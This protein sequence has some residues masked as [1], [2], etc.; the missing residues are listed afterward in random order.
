MCITY[1]SFTGV[2][3]SILF[4]TSIFCGGD[5]L[6]QEI[7]Q[8]QLARQYFDQ[9]DVEKAKD[10]YEKLSR[11]NSNIPLIH[12]SYIELLLVE[13]DFDQALK[14]IEKVNKWFPKNYH[15][16][17][18]EALIYR[19]SKQEKKAEEIFNGLLSDVKSSPTMLRSTAQYLFQKGEAEKAVEFYL[20]GRKSS[21]NKSDFAIELANVYRRMNN[22]EAMIEEYLNFI[23][24][25]PSNL[26]YVQ[27]VMQ[28]LLTE[29]EDLEALQ[30][31]LYDKI[32]KNPDDLVYNELLIWVNMQ[33]KDFYGAFIQA[34]AIDKRAKEGGK[35]LLDIGIMALHNK[36]YKNGETIFQYII[37]NYNEGFTY[38]IARRYLISAREEIVKNTYPVDIDQIKHLIEDYNKLIQDLGISNVSLEAMRSKALLHAFYLNERDTAINL[39]QKII[40]TQRADP[41]LVAKAKL[42]LGDI[43]LLMNQPW[44]STLLYGQVEKASKDTP[45]GYLAKL[46]NAKLSYYKGD[47]ELAQS[48]LDVL[49]LATSREIS[50]DAISLSLLIQNN[51][52]FD[53]TEEAM[54]DYARIDLILFQNKKQ[55]ALNHLDSMIIKFPGHALTD[56]IWWR[57]AN[58]L[59]ELGQFEAS[60]D[61][62]DQIVKQY[63]YDILSDDAYFL[64]G[65]ILEDYLN[66]PNE[67]MEIYQS[68]LKN[69]PGSLYTSEARK[70]YRSLRGDFLN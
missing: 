17:I 9:G 40:A 4:C 49:K 56:E 2:I 46:K 21:G 30:N 14:Y 34:R 66:K 63:S 52:A 68:L 65:T 25:N 42:D 36:D 20:Q 39:L 53:S 70:R 24:Q 35:R 59:L 37:Q 5:L 8:A 10:I 18:D 32:Q 27:N 13:E 15:Y 38:E 48:H 62:L 61:L 26:S 60:V 28:N 44:E 3:F 45:I 11:D 64:M 6:A 22:K 19:Q 54:R 7:N 43:Y 29:T 33:L 23:N 67:A 55:E 41:E 12:N 1:K 16:K 51:I 69:Y 57:K 58:I 50:N 31:V 47:F